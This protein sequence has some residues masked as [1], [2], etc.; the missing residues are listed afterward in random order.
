MVN[1]DLCLTECTAAKIVTWKCQVNKF[2]NGRY[3]MDLGRYL[4]TA[5]GL[6]I[7]FNSNVIIG[8]NGPYE[9]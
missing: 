5:L 8:N 3:D 1:V 9:G 7:K 2:S 6:D 4:I